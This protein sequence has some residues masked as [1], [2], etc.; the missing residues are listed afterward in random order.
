MVYD[1]GFFKTEY[2][3]HNCGKVLDYC[4]YEDTKFFFCIFCKK[5]IKAVKE[6]D[7]QITINVKSDLEMNEYDPAVLED[8]K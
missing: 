5:V 3:K 6:P 7:I 2:P 4:T 8:L 1:T